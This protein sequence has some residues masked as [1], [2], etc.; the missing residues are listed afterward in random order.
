MSRFTPPLTRPTQMTRRFTFSDSIRR[1]R[2]HNSRHRQSQT[3][4]SLTTL[5]TSR[6]IL[7]SVSPTSTIHTYP[8]IRSLSHLR[9]NSILTIGLR[10]TS[11]IRHSSRL[12]NLAQSHQILNMKMRILNQTI[13]SILR[14]ANLSY[15]TP[16]ILI[17][18]MQQLTNRISQ[19]ALSFNRISHLITN[20]H[21]IT[22]KHRTNRVKHRITSARLRTSLI[23]TL[24]NTTINS[25][26]NIMLIHYY[27]RVLSSRQS[28]RH[29][30]RQVTIRMRHVNLRHQRTMLINRLLAHVNRLK[31]RHTA[32]RD[33]L[34]SSLRI[35]PTLTRIRNRHSRL[36]ANLFLSPTSSRQHIGATT[37][38]RRRSIDRFV[39]PVSNS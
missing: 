21:R 28:K 18:K 37:M 31:L 13:P 30:S 33:P 29:Q 14:R 6:P 8:N 12:I 4:M 35:L 24:T 26:I 5:S 23:I 9:R 39:S 38:N 16:S 15:T 32:H 7:R 10:Q 27:S 34:T 3:L 17:S 2:I 22:R 36:N 1:F 20:R 11:T 25:R 19:R